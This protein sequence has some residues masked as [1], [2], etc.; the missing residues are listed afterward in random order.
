MN[1]PA[2]RRIY[3]MR[4]ASVTYFDEQGRPLDPRHVPLN[5]AG[6][7]QVAATARWLAGVPLDRALCSGL[8]RTEQTARAVLGDRDLPLLSDERFKEIRAGRLREIL[9]R[10]RERAIAYAYDGAEQPGAAFIGGESWQSFAERVLTAWQAW[11][12]R[13]DWNDLLLVAHDA[14]NRVI[15][16]HIVGGGL[17]SLKAFEQD[18]AC[19]NLIETDSSP[20]GRPRCLLRAVN[21]T[22]WDPIRPDQRRTVM[23]QVWCHYRPQQE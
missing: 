10:Q 20:D 12:A 22:A 9:P 8:P 16:S 13:D 3:L 18:P 15:L 2:R 5:P 17:H 4:H 1:R 11:L 21:L 7:E 19:F 23:E 6:R 14:V